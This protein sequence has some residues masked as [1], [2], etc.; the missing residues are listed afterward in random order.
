MVFENTRAKIEL[1]VSGESELSERVVI[2]VGHDVTW[3]T[4]APFSFSTLTLTINMQMVDHCCLKP[5]SALEM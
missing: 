2:R 4:K 3:G 1:T 5:S